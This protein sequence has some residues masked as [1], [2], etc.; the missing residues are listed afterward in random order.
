MVDEIQKWE[1]KGFEDEGVFV[2]EQLEELWRQRQ[3]DSFT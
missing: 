2:I 3:I 1:I